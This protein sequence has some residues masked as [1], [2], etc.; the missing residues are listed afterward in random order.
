MNTTN[1]TSRARRARRRELRRMVKD[2]PTISR[3][4]RREFQG[5]RVGSLVTYR[6]AGST[7][8]G[9]IVDLIYRSRI[10]LVR[11]TATRE[12][13]APWTRNCIYATPPHALTVRSR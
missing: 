7:Y 5:L 3:T 13:L 8:P 4:S 6:R 1:I 9:K 10:A 12:G 11:A 2:M